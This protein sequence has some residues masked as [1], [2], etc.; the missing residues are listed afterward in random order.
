MKPVQPILIDGPAGRLEVAVNDP[1]GPHR[2][3][4]LIAHPLHRGTI[5]NKLVVTLAKA[6]FR[7][8]YYCV[9]PNY[10]GVGGSIGN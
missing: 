4:A 6:F 10:R 1:G 7:L 8:G 3:V 5:D 2:G 9:R